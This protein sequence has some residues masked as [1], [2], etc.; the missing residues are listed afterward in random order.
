MQSKIEN[1]SSLERRLD[2]TLPLTEIDAE[3]ESRLKKLARTVRLKG[4]RPGH[5]PLKIVER[6]YGGQVRQEVLGDTVQKSFGEAVREQ[7]L[8]VAGFPKIEAAKAEDGAFGFSATFEVYP[9]VTLGDFS[10]VTIARPA[11]TVGDAEVDKTLQILRRQ[12]T[13]FEE[14]SRAAMSGDQ[15][16]LDYRGTIDGVEFPGGSGN[17]QKVVLGDG[18]LLKGFEENVMNMMAGASKTFELRFPDD[19][20]GKEVRGKTAQFEAKVKTVAAP[21]VPDVDAEFAKSLGVADGDL[22]KMREEVRAN[23]ERE[24]EGRVKSKLKEKVMQALGEHSQV[25]LPKTLVDGE[26]ARLKEQ[27]KN[28]APKEEAL[29]AEARKRVQLGLIVAELV[30]REDLRAKPE[31]V[32]AIIQRHAQGYEHPDEVVRWYYAEPARLKEAEGLA[33][34]DNVVEWVLGKAK[35]TDTPTT[36]DELMGN[37]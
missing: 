14:V 35:A 32:R 37:K 30:K 28:A 26:L 24:V 1:L 27:F 20:H 9:E 21:V 15:V 5:V 7:N 33:L 25:E 13:R 12:R 34:E 16:T 6:Q 11:V 8:R 36:F 31:Q 3:V 19:Y 18:L 4:F 22:A 23:L 17:D 10:N 2:V 29:I